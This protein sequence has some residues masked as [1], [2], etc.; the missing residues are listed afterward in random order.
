MATALITGASN[1]IGLE[2]A[3]VHA[4]KGDNLVLVA[5]SSEKLAAIKTE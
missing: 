4:A 3:R 1:G 5:R 2:L